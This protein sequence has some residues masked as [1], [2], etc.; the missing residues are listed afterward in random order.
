MTMTSVLIEIDR[1]S[2]EK[3]V[4]LVPVVGSTWNYLTGSRKNAFHSFFYWLILL[5]VAE[6]TEDNPSSHEGR[7]GAPP[8]II[9]HSIMGSHIETNKHSNSGSALTTLVPSA[10]SIGLVLMVYVT[11]TKKRSVENRCPCGASFWKHGYHASPIAVPPLLYKRLFIEFFLTL[12]HS[13][14]TRI[15]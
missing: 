14:D 9:I 7:V 1:N 12:L 15:S 3:P 5:L 6:G 11:K 10:R 2:V 13:N 8:L 4:A